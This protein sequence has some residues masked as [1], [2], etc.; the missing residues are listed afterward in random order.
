MSCLNFK[1]GL[2]PLRSIFLNS[3]LTEKAVI[4]FGVIHIL[5]DIYI[6]VLPIP[7]VLGLQLE[8]RTKWSVC[9]LFLVGSVVRLVY[10]KNIE[11]VDPTWDFVT[12]SILSILES[13]AAV[14]VA[15]MPTW[16]PL[17]RFLG[18]GI[19]SYFSCSNGEYGNGGDAE[20]PHYGNNIPIGRGRWPSMSRGGKSTHDKH[21]LTSSGNRKQDFIH[22]GPE[23]ERYE[24]ERGKCGKDIEGPGY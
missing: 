6:L 2:I 18:C 19:N 20:N 7:V 21:Y 5:S 4:A 3:G 15:C 24:Y 8:K 1:A 11:T 22:A 17:F 14:M 23:A 16:R 9:S 10:A 13:S 12:I